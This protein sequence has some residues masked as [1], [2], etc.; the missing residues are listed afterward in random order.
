MAIKVGEVGKPVNYPTTF[1][2]SSSTEMTLKFVSP[3]G[4][5]L[6]LTQTGGR[7]SA[8]AVELTNEP[9]IQKDGSI[10]N[11]TVPAST[12]MQIT[13]IAS[14]FTEEGDY[15]ICGTYQDATPK[16]FFGDENKFP[17]GAAC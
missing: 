10:K 4:V 2:L 8:P 1:D 6:E 14:D 5:V 15:T 11:Q 7:V 12:Y 17:I 3:S 13:T 9:V 16:T